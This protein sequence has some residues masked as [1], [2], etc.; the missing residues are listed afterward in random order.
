[1]KR[2]LMTL[3][4]G[5]AVSALQAQ[6]IRDL[7]K[8]MP[9]SLMPYLTTN[10]RLDLMDFVDAGMKSKITNLLDGT[11]E[12]TRLTDDSL[13]LQ[14]SPALQIDLWKE[15][16]DSSVVVYL[17]RTYQVGEHQKETIVDQYDAQWHLISSRTT[18]STLFYRDEKY[19]DKNYQMTHDIHHSK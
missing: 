18:D 17:R 12:M 5:A 3:C 13:T 7:F 15:Q 11:T 14:M 1:M 4:L 16:A 2:I 19:S 6:T 10:N 8:A 9:D